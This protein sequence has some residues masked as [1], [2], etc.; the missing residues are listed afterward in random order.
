VSA[1]A[2][3]PRPV[4]AAV[5]TARVTRALHPDL[6]VR[7]PRATHDVS[8]FVLVRV[9]TEHG[10]EGYGEVSATPNWNGEDAVTAEHV[11]RDVLA[12]ALV[13]RPLAPVAACTVVMDRAIAA[14]PFAKAGVNTALWDALGR[15]WGLPVVD[16]L[17]GARRDRVAIK[18]SLSGD[19]DELEAAH[20]AAASMGF[21]AFKLKVGREPER[22]V[23]RFARTRELVG[24]A[25]L[26]ADANGA[27]SRLQ[28]MRLVPALRDLGAAFAEQPL[29][30][31]DVDGMA[32]LRGLG[33]PVVADESIYSLGDLAQ[34]VRAGAADAVSIYVGKSGGLERAV[35]AASVC[36][37]FGLGVIVGSN[38]EM[39]VGA[40]AQ[41]HVA[42]AC[43]GIGD[44]PS[45]ING[46]HLYPADL[47][48]APL[49]L[50][51][52]EARLPAGPGLGVTPSE[53]VRRQF[54]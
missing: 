25:F 49:P 20:A 12:P 27:W 6:V 41:T 23:A 52:T 5:E 48:E 36:A 28:A 7:G 47:L 13:G 50:T 24:D 30:A 17:G 44:I 19:G 26:G 39:A 32:T 40:A 22:D 8:S 38:G 33:L 21:T 51:A 16:L 2:E 18:I 1:A 34:A 43:E 37:A 45:D 15:T 3:A 42:C 31:D 14:H 29:A 54:S 53:D 9:I 11:I 35:A 4:V 10:A 46:P